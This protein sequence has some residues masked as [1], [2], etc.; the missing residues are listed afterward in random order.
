METCPVTGEPV[1]KEIKFGFF[2]RT[3]YFCCE[4]C[5]EAAKKNP[6]KFIKP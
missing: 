2:G 3:V 5:L 1:N 6:E 4:S